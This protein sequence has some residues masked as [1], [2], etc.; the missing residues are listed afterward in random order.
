MKKS[1]RFLLFSA[2]ASVAIGASAQNSQKLFVVAQD[3]EGHAVDEA[4][5]STTSR[6]SFSEAGVEVFSGDLL[7]AVFNYK[8]IRSL[9]FRYGGQTGI[10]FIEAAKALKLRSNPVAEVLEF[11]T[12]PTEPA[13]L[14][15][16]D[17]KGRVRNR[18]Q[19]WKGEGVDVAQLAP[20][21][22]F[23]TVNKTTLKFIKK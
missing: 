13:T 10:G 7:S 16:T 3:A 21:L 6:L 14:T 19:N 4:A 8:D 11:A 2:I 15:I 22:Y 12:N 9:G 18:V 5:V 1:A 20:G 17:L 23:V